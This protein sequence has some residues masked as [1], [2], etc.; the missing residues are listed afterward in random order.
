MR[1]GSECL[2]LRFTSFCELAFLFISAFWLIAYGIHWDKQLERGV[3]ADYSCSSSVLFLC[4]QKKAKQ[5]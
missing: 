2:V 3:A 4:H 5:K 1:A